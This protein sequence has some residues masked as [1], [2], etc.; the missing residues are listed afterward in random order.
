MST[1]F[2]KAYLQSPACA[3]CDVG[4][5]CFC[6][7]AMQGRRTPVQ[8]KAE[9]LTNPVTKNLKD[10]PHIPGTFAPWMEDPAIAGVFAMAIKNMV[11]R[12]TPSKCSAGAS[13]QIHHPRKPE[14]FRPSVD[15]WDLLPDAP[16]FRGR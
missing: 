6:P 2:R 14:P 11:E 13:C 7:R 15:E 12:E 4:E 1:Q 5:P 16:G 10:L 3:R 9:A 8:T